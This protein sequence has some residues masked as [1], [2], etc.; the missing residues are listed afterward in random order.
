MLVVTIDPLIQPVLPGMRLGLVQ[1]ARLSVQPHNAALWTML[2]ELCEHMRT[3]YQGKAA[4]DHPAIAA[5]RRVYRALG[6]DPSHYRPANEALLRRVLSRRPLPQI[7]TVVDINNYVS[8]ESGFALGCY[9]V[10]QIQGDIVLRRGPPGEQYAPIGKPE[11]D[12]SNRLVLA[13]DAGIFGSPTADSQRTMVTPA[14]SE[15]L[16]VIFAFEATTAALDHAIKRTV[17]LLVKFCDATIVGQTS[18]AAEHG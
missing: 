14:T 3:V 13:D 12:A 4:A 1:A 8:L 17:D 16:F 11:V 5:T 9:D 10:A 2:E 18:I 7:N 6:D 15:A